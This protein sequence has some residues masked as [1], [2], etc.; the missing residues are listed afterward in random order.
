MRPSR[1]VARLFLVFVLLAVSLAAVRQSSG[2]GQPILPD[3]RT[4]APSGLDIQTAQLSDG[5]THYLL[6]FDNTVGNWGGRLEIAAD[7]AQSRDL[8]QN[9][10][11]AY[12]DGNL[13]AHTK[14]AS[15][16]VYH[17]THNHFHFADFA[18][19]LLLQKDAKGIYRQTTRRGT[20]SSFCIIDTIRV[21]QLG[22]GA[23]SYNT[24]NAVRQGLSAGWADVYTAGLPEQWIDLGTRRPADGDYAIQS[25]ADPLD[26]LTESND[27]NNSATT[28]FTI[29]RGNIAIGQQF[30]T[31]TL[32]PGKGP[33]GTPV[34]LYCTKLTPGDK[35]DIRWGGPSTS[36]LTTVTVDSQNRATASLVIP[37]STLGNHYVYATNQTTG[38]STL[39]LFAT[40]A[41]MELDATSGI[42]GS[43]LG[44]SL[45]GF[46][47][48]EEITL[49]Y[50]TSGS[51]TTVL[52]KLVANGKGSASGTG[53]IP[54]SV[55][56]A[57]KIEAKGGTSRAV[58]SAT[59][60]VDP[61]LQFIPSTAP[62]GGRS[63]P[64]LRGFRKYETV[65]LTLV[66]E[67]EDLRTV[68]TSSTG[69]TNATA[70]NAFDIPDD[71]DPGVYAIEAVGN[72][73][74]VPVTAVFTVTASQQSAGAAS[75]TS[76]T[77]TATVLLPIETSTP[78]MEP[79]P[80]TAPP[81]PTPTETSSATAEVDSPATEETVS[82][83]PIDDDS[84]PAEQDSASIGTPST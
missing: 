71:L 14:V 1:P 42:V 36:V 3:L 57:H 72:L 28:Y 12:N 38:A 51:T 13:V 27:A 6:R 37:D 47:A 78:T 55:F 49:R 84:D 41:D 65:T 74:G 53:T 4:L 26:K 44:I 17:P 63:S 35:L 59:F 66:D 46:V 76:P 19:Y 64:S 43:A 18:T 79:S 80:T 5:R 22:S 11:D 69:S 15:D 33:V 30:P 16:L 54:V 34:D 2:V 8:Y 61:S 9:V 68:R 81:E 23:S 83:P 48:Q 75:V 62:A 40:T 70:G 24:C 20:K 39:A 45:T 56:G 31:C 60:T 58:V 25:T 7:L 21:A 32:S 10:Y 29:F 67:D 82:D 77:P 50:T 73:S 52:A